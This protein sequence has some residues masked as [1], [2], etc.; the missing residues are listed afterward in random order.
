MAVTIL[1]E[2]S[3]SS[4]RGRADLP[5]HAGCRRD[6]ARR[7]SREL[8]KQNIV[9]LAYGDGNRAGLRAS[10]AGSAQPDRNRRRPLDCPSSSRRGLSLPA[11]R[12]RST[13]AL[14]ATVIVSTSA[15]AWDV[16]Q[17][18]LS[19]SGSPSTPIPCLMTSRSRQQFHGDAVR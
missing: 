2:R 15:D 7:W 16:L 14:A 6:Q 12:R 9:A 3:A 19:T 17:P 1:V 11:T 18:Q 5:A 10:P 8:V 4:T 13:G